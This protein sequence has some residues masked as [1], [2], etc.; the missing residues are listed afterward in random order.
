MSDSLISRLE[1]LTEPSRE[2]DAEI[3]RANGWRED[4]TF[5]GCWFCPDGRIDYAVPRYTGS[6]DVAL[7]S[8]PEPGGKGSALWIRLNE[9]GGSHG[10]GESL[11]SVD[12]HGVE[13]VEGA[14][15]E[16]LKDI[17]WYGTHTSPAIALLIAIERM[18]AALE[19][20][21]KG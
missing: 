16:D 5:K 1:A 14:A 20:A 2:I 7:A 11:W 18:R 10:S 19:A 3:A 9:V 8:V 15:P 21:Q 12:L 13:R 4:P 17:N 6:L